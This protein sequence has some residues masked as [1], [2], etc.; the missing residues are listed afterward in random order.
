VRT[1][2]YGGFGLVAERGIPKP[3]FNAFAML[4]RLGTERLKADSDSVLATRRVDGSIALA[5][6]N[7]AAPYGTGAAYTPLPAEAGLAKMFT[8]KLTGVAANS[9]VRI[10]R[11]D[12]DHGNVVKAFDAMGRPAF[13]SR[14]QIVALRAAGKEAPPEAGSLRAGAITVSVPTQGLVL[15]TVGVKRSQ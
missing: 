13:P 1:P 7:Y 15:I 10:W 4:H 14:E 8:I 12:S 5:A 3:A 9:P 11:L 6:W 2:F